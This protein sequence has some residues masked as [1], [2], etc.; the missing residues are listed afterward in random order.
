VDAERFHP[1]YRSAA[2]R[3]ELGVDDAAVLAVCVGRLGAEKGL[4]VALAGLH[5]VQARA[6]TRVVCAIA[7]D[8]PHADAYRQQAPPGT[9]FLGR[10]SG[11]ALS[12]L[13]AS[14]DLF[15]FPSITDTF[16]NVL[17]EAMA[18]GVPVIG[19]D[20][21]PTTELLTAGGGVTFPQGNAH[22]FAAQVI[23]LADDPVRRRGL[24]EAALAF[25]R[26]CTWDRV[27]EDLIADYTRVFAGAAPATAPA[28][29]STLLNPLPPSR[30]QH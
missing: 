10:L 16:G 14:G 11:S 13:Y 9:R 24:A 28:A 27:F 19:A 25:A 20:V 8:G 5:E 26:R 3:A 7:G 30:L 21:G 4:D 17:L 1:R 23:A 15:L 6:R 12:E 29:S 2:L 18:S 22:A